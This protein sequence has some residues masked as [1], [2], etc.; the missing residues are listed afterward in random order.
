VA[1]L[2]AIAR[3]A[4]NPLAP[5]ISTLTFVIGSVGMIRAETTRAERK[6]TAP[7]GAGPVGAGRQLGRRPNKKPR[8]RCRSSLHYHPLA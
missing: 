5:Y 7:V 1:R 6:S 8:Q 3:V 2:T 4:P